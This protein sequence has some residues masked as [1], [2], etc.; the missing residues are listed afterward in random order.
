MK[1]STLL[2]SMIS[3]SFLFFI[4][5]PVHAQQAIWEQTPEQIRQTST[6]STG[7]RGNVKSA[8]M[9]TKITE[10]L[11]QCELRLIFRSVNGCNQCGRH[12]CVVRAPATPARRA[13]GQLG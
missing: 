6:V 4:L 2:Y 11:G 3:I 5:T 10:V 9:G 12:I 1:Q 7:K 8:L 13:I